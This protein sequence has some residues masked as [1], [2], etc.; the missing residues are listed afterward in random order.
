MN[1]AAFATAFNAI[2]E[3]IK[4]GAVAAG[5]D[6]SSGGLIT[7]LLEMCFADVDLSAKIDLTGLPDTDI[8]KLLFAENS[9][10]VVQAT[11]D[12]LENRLTGAG[13]EFFKIGSVIEGETLHLKNG[14]QQFEFDIPSLRRTW[15]KT[16]FLLDQQQSGLE[17]ATERYENFD[18]QPLRY[19]FPEQFNGK[20]PKIAHN[21]SKPRI[22]AAIIREKGSNSEREMAYAMDLAGFDVKDVHMT[23]LIS[24]RET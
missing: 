2:Q 12:R 20:L 4:E 21:S 16:S 24:G 3:L 19:K 7:T 11:D 18:R 15:S 1:A 10:I 17:K 22:K 14:D 9:G 6:I 23:D 8:I 5:H 13:I